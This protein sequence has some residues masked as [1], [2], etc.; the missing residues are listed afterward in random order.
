MVCDA[1]IPLST[2][3]LGRC[4]Y[5]KTVQARGSLGSYALDAILDRVR[6]AIAEGVQQIWLT[7]EDTGA[8]GIDLGI[9]IV[10]LL[11]AIRKE[12]ETNVTSKE[13]GVMVRLGMTNP[14]Y[15]LEHLPAFAEILTSEHFFEFLH[16]PVQS[17]ADPVLEN[18]VSRAEV[19]RVKIFSR[20]GNIPP[21]TSDE[22]VTT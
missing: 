7:S 10:D 4:T 3:C 13:K 19:W 11:Q 1:V 20:S 17:G 15:I 22:C 12:L 2:G 18:M 9:T 6:T 5:C 16:V 8:Y 21:L 14:P